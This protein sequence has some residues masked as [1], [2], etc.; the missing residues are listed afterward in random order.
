MKN[1][2]LILLAGVGLQGF[3]VMMWAARIELRVQALEGK[4][5]SSTLP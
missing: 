1:Q 3:G 5:T 2:H 4:A